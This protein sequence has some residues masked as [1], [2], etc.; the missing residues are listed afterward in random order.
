MMKNG[1]NLLM[2]LVMALPVLLGIIALLIWV[3]PQAHEI[4]MTGAKLAVIP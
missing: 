1:K 3:V 2:P 4:I